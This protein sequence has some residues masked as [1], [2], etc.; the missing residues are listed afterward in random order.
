MWSE[1]LAQCTA[2]MIYDFHK[3]SLKLL[4]GKSWNAVLNCQYRRTCTS[5]SNLLLPASGL[6]LWL[7]VF[8]ALAGLT[9]TNDLAAVPQF[10]F[11]AVAL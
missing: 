1:S 3:F 10:C 11:A 5:L 4:S 6:S 7:C 8:P 2:Y 9:G